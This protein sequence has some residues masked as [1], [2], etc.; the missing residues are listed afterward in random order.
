MTRLATRG[1]MLAAGDRQL[2][3]GLS[4][5]LEAGQTWVILG[6][7]GSGKTTLLHT[8]AGLRPADGGKVLLDNAPIDT[9]PHRE[10]AR[11][12][13]ILLQDHDDRFPGT[14]LETVLTGR[15]PYASWSQVFG[16]SSEDRELALKALQQ[17]DLAGFANRDTGSLSGGE[18]R[19]MQLATL[20]AQDPGICLLDE[21]TNHLDLGHQTAMLQKFCAAG[22]ESLTVIVLH[23]INLGLRY[24][25]HGILMSGAGETTAG[26]LEEIISRK[27]LEQLYRCPLER[28]PTGTREVFLPA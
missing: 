1:V 23:D 25:S 13:G 11:R 8:L 24:A 28:I 20:L 16:D 26:P 18:R 5:E 27:S 12:L 22:S 19:R 17:V 9:Y 21:P 2:V 10:R 3:T 14:V 4:V 15:Y 6:P 7:N